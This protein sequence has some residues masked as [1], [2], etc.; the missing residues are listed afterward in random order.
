MLHNWNPIVFGCFSFVGR[1][2]FYLVKY[3]EKVME[4]FHVF[5]IRYQFCPSTP[6][7]SSKK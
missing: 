2:L 5:H 3:K 1:I 6:V 7:T 4:L